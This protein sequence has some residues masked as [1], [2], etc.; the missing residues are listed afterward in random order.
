MHPPEHETPRT[1]NL[2]GLQLDLR[3]SVILVASTLLLMLD[4]YHQFLLGGTYAQALFSKAV[5]RTVYYLVVPLLFIVLLFRD[6]PAKYG[7]R[8][9]NWRTGL[10]WGVGLF[11]LAVPLLYLSARTPAMVSYYTQGSRTIAQ[12]LG[13]SALDLLGWEFLF[14]GFILFGLYRLMGPSAIVAQAVP[15]ALVH[16]GKPELETLS[17]IFGGILFGWLAWKAQSFVYPYLLHWLVN[18]FVILVAMGAIAWPG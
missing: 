1:L 6:P 8:I 14:R 16:I 15:F 5:E 9:G 3:A 11:A 4:G 10:K 18:T 7:F 2:G 17:T 12:I 13:T